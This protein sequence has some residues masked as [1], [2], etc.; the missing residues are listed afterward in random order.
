M[1]EKAMKGDPF[2]MDVKLDG[3]RM[4]IHIKDNSV[5]M[6]T[7]NNNDYTNL[8]HPLGEI[9]MKNVAVSSC[10]LDGEVLGYDGIQGKFT[11]FGG[12]K[13]L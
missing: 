7:R 10:I 5:Q 1:V 8:Y 3:E 4:M 12:N 6:F 11:D 9:V 2:L 13:V